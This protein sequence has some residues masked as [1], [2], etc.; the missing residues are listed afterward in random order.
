[1]VNTAPD[2]AWKYHYQYSNGLWTVTCIWRN[3]KLNNKGIKL[4]AKGDE[5]LYKIIFDVESKTVS[6]KIT[7]PTLP[8]KA[9]RIADLS[10]DPLFFEELRDNLETILLTG[11][12]SSVKPNENRTVFEIS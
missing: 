4:W 10:D 5:G 2:F 12:Y 8:P 1:M 11:T 9:P 7:N 6:V 3:F